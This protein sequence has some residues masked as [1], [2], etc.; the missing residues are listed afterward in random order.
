MAA[1]D[2]AERKRP[3]TG[4]VAI[5]TGGGRG[6]GRAM[7][8]G[9]AQA[10]AHVVATAARERDEIERLARDADAGG[11]RDAIHPMLADVTYMR[12]SFPTPL[13]YPLLLGHRA[14]RDDVAWR[15]LAG[16]NWSA[17]PFHATDLRV[18]PWQ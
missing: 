1:N 16:R 7:A 18:L 9:L 4:R 17:P 12:R 15:V 6:I 2:G 3:L 8:L 10:G 5:V 14:I 11:W 13:S